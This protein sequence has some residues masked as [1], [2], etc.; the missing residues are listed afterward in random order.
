MK[1]KLFDEICKFCE[2]LVDWEE[3]RD[4]YIQEVLPI[5]KDKYSHEYISIEARDIFINKIRNLT[6]ATEWK[7]IVELIVEIKD[8]KD[9]F[10][11]DQRKQIY[12]LVFEKLKEKYNFQGFIH[13][14]TFENFKNIMKEGYIYSRNSLEL[15][16]ITSCDIALSEVIEK[17]DEDVKNYVRCYWRVQTPTN[18]DNEGIKPQKMLIN[19]FEAHSPNPVILILNKYLACDKNVR[20]SPI[21]AGSQ[22]SKLYE[23]INKEFEF[24]DIFHNGPIYDFEDKKFV[25]LRKNAEFLYPNKLAVNNIEKIIFRNQADYNRAILEFGKDERFCIDN[26][27]FCNN[28]LCIKT[29][30]INCTN[31]NIEIKI[32]YNFGKECCKNNCKLSDYKHTIKLLDQD[33]NV[34]INYD[35][36]ILFNSYSNYSQIFNFY[37]KSNAKYVCYYIDD[38][39]CIKAKIND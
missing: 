8:D 27:Q 37:N 19:N 28:W 18:Y 23:Y 9:K 31:S 30:E 10:I 11:Y 38:I 16:N 29:Y 7:N 4:Y 1:Q 2:Y 13:S 35:D 22:Y 15:H 34:I 33:Q 25:I 6:S 5:L 32:S 24:N 12:S 36:I 3:K 39:E 26:S 21:N 17:T 20:F 14:T